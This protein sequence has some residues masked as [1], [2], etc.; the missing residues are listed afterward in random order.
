[1][2]LLF[3]WGVHVYQEIIL[4]GI[5]ESS[6][7]LRSIIIALILIILLSEYAFTKV[8]SAHYSNHMNIQ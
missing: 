3:A 8:C 4:M 6:P 1:M 5:P 7:K 2:F